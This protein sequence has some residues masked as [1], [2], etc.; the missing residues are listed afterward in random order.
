MGEIITVIDIGTTKIAFLI[1]QLDLNK[2]DI[3]L[4][5]NYPSAGLKRGRI[6]D[7]E[8]LTSSIRKA[9][10]DIEETHKI[11]IKKAYICSSGSDVQG[12]YSDAAIKVKKKEI[13]EEDVN[14]AID[15]ATAIQI[16]SDRQIV[17]ILPVE[18]IVDGIDGIKDPVGMKG[19]RLEAKV[20][21][22]TASSSHIQNLT[23]CCNKAGIEVEDVVIQ[24]VS[25]SE[26]VLSEHEK[27]SGTLVADIGGGSINIAVFYDGYLRH[28]SNYGIGG[29]HITNDLSIGLKIPFREAE[30]IKT[31]FGVAIPDITF[32]SL[33]FKEKDMDI[34]I[35]G[36]D[37]QPLKIPISVV[38]E[39]VYARCEEMVE[40][41][42][43]EILSIS[44][45]T[46]LQS[47]VLTGGT[48]LMKGFNTLTESI[49]SLSARI[50]RPDTGILNLC[51]EMGLDDA[52]I[53]QNEQ[54]HEWISPEFSSAIGTLIYALKIGDLSS[55]DL[56]I[57][58][59]FSKITSWFKGV[60][61]I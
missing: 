49:L 52:L 31:E 24:A 28:I 56:G 23:T 8:S 2:L 45:Q 37:K 30:R 60:L 25:S 19:V 11:K 36:M 51:S 33:K 17:H 16:T 5:K 15:A 7:M 38:K 55:Q 40:I 43:K 61:K 13:T 47:V 50:G 48:S 39:I 32:G 12:A 4:L 42:K 35:L 27:E 9:V 1:A 3:I 26:A 6:V 53:T 10:Q 57:E 44:G 34:E 29:N 21:I 14:L 41:L 58:R 54:W 22:I 20:Y 46:P 18:F 59:I